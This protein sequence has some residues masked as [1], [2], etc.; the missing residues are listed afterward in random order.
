MNEEEKIPEENF[1][2]EKVNENISQQETIEQPETTNQ[3]SDITTSEI[4]EMEVHHHPHVEKKNFKEYL[5]EGLMIFLAVTMGFFAESLRE[6]INDNEKREQYIQSLTEDIQ[7]DTTRINNVIMFDDGKISA[8]NS[9]YQCYDTVI[10][11]LK[12]TSCMGVLI[13]YSK[14]NRAFQLNDRP[15]PNLLMQMVSDFWRSRMLT[16]FLLIKGCTKCITILS[17]PYTRRHRTMCAIH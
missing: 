2:E 1:K 10:G 16:V 8:L 11:N 4:K 6:H 12:A 13:K 5:L 3:T 15:L 17:Q 14:V 7:S 9:M